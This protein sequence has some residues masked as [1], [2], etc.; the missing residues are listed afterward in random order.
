M[1]ISINPSP[2]PSSDSGSKAAVR[3]CDPDHLW[4]RYLHR[5]VELD[6]TVETQKKSSNA[7]FSGAPL[8]CLLVASHIKNLFSSLFFPYPLY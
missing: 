6:R 3:L 5:T 1:A 2:A 7:P 4:F 8:T